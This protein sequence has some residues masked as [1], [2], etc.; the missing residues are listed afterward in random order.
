MAFSFGDT[1]AEAAKLANTYA[2][3]FDEEIPLE[4]F[5]EMC[6]VACTALALRFSSRFEQRNPYLDW[7]LDRARYALSEREAFAQRLSVRKD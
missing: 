6:A 4:L 7:L 1:T 5:P 3:S 2:N